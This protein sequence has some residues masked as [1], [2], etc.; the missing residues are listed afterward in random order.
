MADAGLPGPTRVSAASLGAL[1]AVGVTLTDVLAVTVLRC[2]SLRIVRRSG[3]PQIVSCPAGSPFTLCIEN[4]NDGLGN[5]HLFGVLKRG[6]GSNPTAPV[7]GD[8]ARVVDLVARAGEDPRLINGAVTIQCSPAT[9]FGVR[10]VACPAGKSPFAYC[11]EARNDGK[12]R[13]ALVGIVAANG[14]SD[15]YGLYGQ[16]HAEAKRGYLPKNHLITAVGADPTKVL[17]IDLAVCN[18]RRGF[19]SGFPA[20]LQKVD[21]P[22]VMG[23]DVAA[24]YDYCIVRYRQLAE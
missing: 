14:P 23:P 9:G 8:G 4:G 2:E 6:P 13:R 20:N 21:C 5:A 11:I 12:G 22:L 3:G 7:C 1:L 17:A 24:Q 19:G 16:C 10:K 18:L 15:P